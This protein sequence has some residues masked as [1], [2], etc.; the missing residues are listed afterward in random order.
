MLGQHFLPVIGLKKQQSC[1]RIKTARRAPLIHNKRLNQLLSQRDRETCFVGDPAM[2]HTC[3]KTNECGQNE[4][5]E[6]AHGR[7]WMWCVPILAHLTQ[8]LL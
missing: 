2:T 1:Q 5:S 8:K 6:I 4:R 3:Q 7:L